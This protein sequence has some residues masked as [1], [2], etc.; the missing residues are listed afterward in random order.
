VPYGWLNYDEIAADGSNI[1]KDNAGQPFT[2]ASSEVTDINELALAL[3][4]P[5]LDFAVCYRP[6]R[7]TC[8]CADT[9]TPTG[10]I[11]PCQIN[12]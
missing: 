4:T 9:F 6:Y 8:T 7:I 3:S 11:L 2:N 1:A 10:K 5:P 12:D